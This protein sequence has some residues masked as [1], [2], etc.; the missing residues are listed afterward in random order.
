MAYYVEPTAN[1]TKGFFEFFKY[2][3]TVADGLFFPVLLLVVW[4]IVFV[5]TKTYT[6]PR[7]WTAASITVSFLSIP[8]TIAGLVAPRWM[9]MSFVL[10]AA[11]VLCS[12]WK[13]R[14]RRNETNG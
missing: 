5:A 14:K 1:D 11:G 4:V 7:A 12:N 6:T 9:Y 10:T 2:V 8:L 13:S 3:N